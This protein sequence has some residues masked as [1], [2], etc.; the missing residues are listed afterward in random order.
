MSET[1]D[2]LCVSCGKRKAYPDGFPDR[3]FAEC[4]ECAWNDHVRNKHPEVVRRIRKAA[5][6]RAR[7]LTE[8]DVE[9]AMFT[10]ER[11]Q[12]LGPGADA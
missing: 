11:M 4:W 3:A 10:A 1:M 2:M 8:R 6:K 9:A 7:R 5:K 12:V